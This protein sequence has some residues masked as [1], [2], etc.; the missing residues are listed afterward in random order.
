MQNIFL[1]IF[2]VVVMCEKFTLFDDK[3]V[4]EVLSLIGTSKGVVKGFNKDVEGVRYD[5]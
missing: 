2:L 4:V 3:E 5:C 1:F